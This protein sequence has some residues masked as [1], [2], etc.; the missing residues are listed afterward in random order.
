MWLSCCALFLVTSFA[1]SSGPQEPPYKHYCGRLEKRGAMVVRCSCLP[2]RLRC[3]LHQPPIPVQPTSA[4]NVHDKGRYWCSTGP[5]LAL[6]CAFTAEHC[7]NRNSLRRFSVSPQLCCPA[8]AEVSGCKPT[9]PQSPSDCA[10]RPEQPHLHVSP[11][12]LMMVE[13]I[14]APVRWHSLSTARHPSG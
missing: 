8:L 12:T 4:R 10:Q 2:L 5:S 11:I 1:P 3:L 13:S 6:Y 14:K 9:N 7:R